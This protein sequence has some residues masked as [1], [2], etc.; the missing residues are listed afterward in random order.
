MRVDAKY[1]PDTKKY[2]VV[3][4]DTGTPL[5]HQTHGN[6]VDGGGHS[7]MV[8]AERQKGYLQKYYDKQEAEGK[9][10]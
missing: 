4:A 10:S 9:M 5:M 1:N 7:T 8:T 2:D 6:R 3:D